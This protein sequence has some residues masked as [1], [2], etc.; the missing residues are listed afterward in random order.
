M[1]FGEMWLK[2][3]KP[4]I[5][6]RFMREASNLEL[7]LDLKRSFDNLCFKWHLYFA[8]PVIMARKS[9]NAERNCHFA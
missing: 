4:A 1:L 9:K 6:A 3:K 7:K 2:I 5:L 8:V